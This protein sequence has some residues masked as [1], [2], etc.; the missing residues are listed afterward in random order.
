MAQ[1]VINEI[2]QTYS[3]N[4]GTNAYATVA[5]PITASWGPA[6]QD[7]ETLGKTDY[8]EVLET[9]QFTRFPATQKGLEAFVSTYRGPASN[10]R[11]AKDFSYQLAMTLMT[12]GYDVLTCRVSPGTNA[13]TTFTVGSSSPVNFTVKAKYPGSFGNKLRVTLQK[14]PNYNY[15]NLITYVYD[16]NS[17]I[18]TAVENLTFVFNLMTTEE[19]QSDT[20]PHLDELESNF[21]TFAV[22]GQIDDKTVFEPESKLLAGGSDKQAD[23]EVSAM[24]DAAKAEATERY[25][26]AGQTDSIYLTAFDT[27]K[28]SIGEDIAKASTIRY[29][30]WLYTAAYHVYDLLKDKLSYNP[31]RIIS[32][33]WDDQNVT[34]IDDEEV[35]KLLTLS[36]LH[37]K[38][39]DTAYA[40]RCATAYKIGR[41]HV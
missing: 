33:G 2:S 30:E 38:L 35:Q 9:V 4:I 29:M 25:T 12:A 31:N 23:E 32:P 17:G 22:D 7:P 26:A 1:I 11:L 21:L 20:I 40:S 6:Y 39:M 14:V 41:A 10:Y 19:T 16:E 36:P 5:M 3:Y 8:N 27:L 24:I 13:S 15:W 37:I 28:S 18:Q 34:A